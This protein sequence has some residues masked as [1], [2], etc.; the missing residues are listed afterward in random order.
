[1]NNYYFIVYTNIKC[2]SDFWEDFSMQMTF[3]QNGMEE[4]LE[5]NE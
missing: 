5:E 4:L 1:M 2:P 3:L